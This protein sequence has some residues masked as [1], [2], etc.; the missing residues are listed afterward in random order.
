[1]KLLPRWEVSPEETWDL[2]P[3]YAGEE[4][5][6][7]DLERLSSLL[8]K[9]KSFQKQLTSA[10]ALLDFIKSLEALM[11]IF[12]R[13]ASYPSL[14][15][16]TDG[17]H[18]AF[19]AQTMR[20][21][22]KGQE[23]QAALSFVEPELLALGE[24]AW[25]R[26]CRQEPSLAA[27]RPYVDRVLRNKA[28]VLSQQGEEILGTLSSALQASA[29]IYQRA[30]AA[31]LSF[32][33]VEHQGKKIP[34]TVSRY[35]QYLASPD[36]ELREKAHAALG[37]GLRGLQTTLA[38]TLALHIQKNV[39]VARLRGY[40]SAEAMFLHPQDIPMEVY[41]NVLD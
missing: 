34:L 38:T 28:H 31:D 4:D 1:M 5:W 12:S 15:Q 14:Q 26:F 11:E 25:E 35:D 24:E 20:V 10:Q 39:A 13:V 40:P 27:Y 32:P 29:T 23:M 19:Q 21:S 22:L 17:A 16:A 2:S 7:K 6:E 41:E 9:V 30:S 33:P 37:E 36:G 3:L 18:P 8:E